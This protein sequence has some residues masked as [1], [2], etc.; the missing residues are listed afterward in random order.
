MECIRTVFVLKRWSDLDGLKGLEEYRRV[1]FFV[2][3]VRKERVCKERVCKERV[4]PHSTNRFVMDHNGFTSVPSSALVLYPPMVPW[5]KFW[6]PLLD[7]SFRVEF[8][9]INFEKIRKV[10]SSENFAHLKLRRW[11]RW[12]ITC[13]STK[14]SYPKCVQ[15]VRRAQSGAVNVWWMDKNQS[16]PTKLEN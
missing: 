4:A 15:C 11:I 1:P 13:K 8:E 2:P 12:S 7:L 9:I 10:C 6:S 5:R 14:K 16:F 3:C